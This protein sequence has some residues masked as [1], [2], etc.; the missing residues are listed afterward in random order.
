LA[1]VSASQIEDCAAPADSPVTLDPAESA[2]MAGLRYVSDS[3]PGYR[4]R[5]V[6]KNF[7]YLDTE[8]NPIRNQ[9]EIRR[10]KSLAIPPAYTDVWICPNPRG[11]LQATG[12]D[13][14]GRKQ[15]RYHRRWREVRDETKYDRMLSFG[16]VLPQIRA[17]VDED[18]AKQGLPREKV[19]ATVVELL[20]M[21]RIRI[22]NEEYAQENDSY[23]LTTM[24]DEHVQVNGSQVRFRFR[25]KSGREH[26]V[27]VRD[28]RVARVIQRLKGLEGETLFQYQDEAGEIRSVDSDDVNDYLQQI[29]GQ[30][31]TAKDF[32]TWT[33]TVL[34]ARALR[35]LGTPESKT[36]AKRK[37]SE[38]VNAVAG[39][40]GNT[41]AICRKCYVHPR[42]FEAFEEGTLM[43]PEGAAK[44]VD[45]E[46]LRDDETSVLA[47]LREQALKAADEERGA[48]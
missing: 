41:A 8:G 47:L 37:M 31:F 19:L 9:E 34:A 28:R 12:R 20:D 18:L 15:Y 21:G 39:Y 13:A 16:D 40:L 46:G 26:D 38:A 2:K 6:G 22:G 5:R 43:P 1:T 35:Q 33:G 14:R 29:S 32:R 36:D 27:D 42:V 10:I 23:G 45:G 25:G 30:Q 17:R 4:R 44:P 7:V 24:R 3:M 11:H 48:A